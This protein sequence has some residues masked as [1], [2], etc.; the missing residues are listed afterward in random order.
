M[1]D[2]PGEKPKI[3]VDSDW[4]EEARKEKERLI[5]ETEEAGAAGPLPEPTFAEIIN[6]ILM[7]AMI[8]LG[9][10][11]TPD[12]RVI[13]PDL[14]IAKHHI[15]LLAL[16]QEKTKGNLTDDERRLL[17][18]ALYEM[19]MRFVQATT[20]PPSEAAPTA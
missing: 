18:A 3:H 4:K 2:K 15:D 7:Q 12:G 10:M 16:L 20:V 1:A 14:E 5:E 6:M 11:R 17:D 19:R 13:A 9:G 8:G